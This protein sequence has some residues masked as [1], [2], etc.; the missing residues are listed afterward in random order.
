MSFIHSPDIAFD[1]IKLRMKNEEGLMKFGVDFLDE[2]TEGILSN[3]LILVG[4][5]SGAGKTQFCCNV[6]WSN[7]QSGRKVHYIALEA[8]YAEIERRIKYGIFSE[9][10]F[11]RH[12]GNEHQV[13]FK[14]W[15]LGRLSVT[16]ANLEAE[17][18]E[19]FKTKSQGLHTYYKQEA[20]DVKRFIET[21]MSCARDTDLII[22]DHVHYFDFDDA[23]ENRAI[24]E[25]A[26]AARDLAIHQGKPMILVGHIRKSDR[27]STDKVPGMEE[28]HGSSDL[29]KI[30]TK[31][32]TIAPGDNYT[33]DGKAETFMRIVKD[34]FD[35]SLQRHMASLVYDIRKGTYEQNYK[36][37]PEKQKR[38]EEF[39]EYSPSDIPRWV[40]SLRTVRGD[41]DRI[42]Q[43]AAG[44]S[45][46]LPNHA[47]FTR[48]FHEKD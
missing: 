30:A 42:P 12:K 29:F 19:I 6:A 17:A 7:V 41:H 33:R 31:A 28:F 21:V 22:V 3:D 46:P 26:M 16:L 11:S 24:K 47:R 39:R 38:S 23:N 4:A 9:L 8:E 48:G 37:G 36:L 2:A 43:G 40:R 25:I 1:E 20:F 32:I 15:M 45:A 13:S 35:G 18:A 34:R 14:N 27:N 10:Y 5:R 44:R